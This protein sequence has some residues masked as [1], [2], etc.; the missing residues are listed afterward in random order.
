VCGVGTLKVPVGFGRNTLLGQL[1]Q[2]INCVR[3]QLIPWSARRSQLESLTQLTR[4]SC[5]RETLDYLV[6]AG[7]L[8]VGAMCHRNEGDQPCECPHDPLR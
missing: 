8:I 6:M 5:M 2:G 4:H 1:D 7:L 3:T